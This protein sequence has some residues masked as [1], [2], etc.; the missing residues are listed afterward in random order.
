[1]CL[2]SRNEGCYGQCKG[3]VEKWRLVKAPCADMVGHSAQK[4]V[5]EAVA[6]N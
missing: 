4:A 2:L 5:L 6:S 3:S 1:M